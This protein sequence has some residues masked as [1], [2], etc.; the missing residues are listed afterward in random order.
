MK[1]SIYHGSFDES[2]RV[3]IFLKDPIGVIER[4]FNRLEVV[5]MREPL[6]R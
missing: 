2:F 6:A 4:V 1:C 5:S 3:V